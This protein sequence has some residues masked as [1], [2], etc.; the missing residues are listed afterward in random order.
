MPKFDIFKFI[1]WLDKKSIDEMDFICKKFKCSVQFLH[2]I[3][4]IKYEKD[5]EIFDKLGLNI[6][7]FIDDCPVQ[8]QFVSGW[9]KIELCTH[10]RN[11][12]GVIIKNGVRGEVFECEYTD[13][14]YCA[15][16]QTDLSNHKPTHYIDVP[17]VDN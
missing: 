15:V 13:N 8:E 11:I 12:I 9:S 14:G 3:D 10:K 6:D 2:S 7:D 5:K 4:P 16:T 1:D 17:T